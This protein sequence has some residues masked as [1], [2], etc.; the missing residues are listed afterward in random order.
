[1]PAF[2]ERKYALLRHGLR[3]ARLRHNSDG[4]GKPKLP[5]RLNSGETTLNAFVHRHR[6]GNE[7]GR[8]IKLFEG[9]AHRVLATD[10]PTPKS[11]AHRTRRAA[12]RRACPSGMALFWAFQRIPETSIKRPPPKR[13][14]RPVWKANRPRRC[15]R[16][17]KD[18]AAQR[19][20]R[21]RRQ[22][23]SNRPFHRPARDIFAA[24]ACAGVRWYLPPKGIKTVPAPMVES[25]RSLRPRFE[26]MFLS[27][28]AERSRSVKLPERD[29]ADDFPAADKNFNMLGCA[30]GIEEFA[31]DVTDR[32]TAPEHPQA[33][34]AVTSAT[35][36]A[37][38]FSSS[39]SARNASTS[40]GASTTTAIRSCDSLMASSVPSKPSYFFGTASRS[41]R[42]PSASSPMATDTPPAPK[43]L[44]L[45][46]Q[47]RSARVTE[48]PLQLALLG[49][50]SLLH[51]RAAVPRWKRRCATWTSRSRRRSRRGQCR[52][53]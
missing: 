17:R 52:R 48:Q 7:G 3:D 34:L 1:M 21:S 36:V 40:P 29:S 30:V 32:L 44:Q 38:R 13:R 22:R 19:R 14:R 11:T 37:S 16:P 45:F 9:A 43:S 33:L 10:S 47:P 42:R 4:Q 15:T 51:L 12:R 25:K 26:Q 23:P 31:A 8:H 24:I 39:A 49:R 2:H 53:R 20:I 41:M 50:I 35:T 18:S 6:E 27:E 5:A 28:S 46:D